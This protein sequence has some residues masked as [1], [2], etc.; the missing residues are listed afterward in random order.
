M[1]YSRSNNSTSVV[2]RNELSR[3]PTQ[4]SDLPLGAYFTQSDGDINCKI[5]VGDDGT[6]NALCFPKDGDGSFLYTVLPVELVTP[7]YVKV[8]LEY[9]LA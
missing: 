1:N 7:V 6:H 3:P 9:A 4:F 8:T 2:K 5:R